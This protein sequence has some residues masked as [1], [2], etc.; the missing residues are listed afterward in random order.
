MN[1]LGKRQGSHLQGS[2]SK[3]HLGR[4]KGKSRVCEKAMHFRR[5]ESCQHY[6]KEAG[7]AQDG[8]VE[9]FVLSVPCPMGLPSCSPQ[10]WQGSSLSQH[11]EAS[12][13]ST[14]PAAVSLH[15]YIH[16]PHRTKLIGGSHKRGLACEWLPRSVYLKVKPNPAKNKPAAM[17]SWKEPWASSGEPCCTEGQ[18]QRA[19]V[20]QNTARAP[21]WPRAAENKARRHSQTQCLGT[22]LT[23][24]ALKRSGVFGSCTSATSLQRK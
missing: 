9:P 24:T 2:G 3:S 4:K 23:T 18:R 8:K 19:S 1:H 20:S 5:G 13:T 14:A 15:L 22:A 12:G 17:S 11:S 21:L 16:H 7:P 10:T 6:Y